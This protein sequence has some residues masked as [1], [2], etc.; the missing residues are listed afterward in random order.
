MDIIINKKPVSVPIL[1][2]AA[3]TSL[4]ILGFSSARVASVGGDEVGVFVNNL[5]GTISVK[6]DA[7]SSIYN[8]IYTDFYTLKK[9]ERTIKMNKSH[10]DEVRIK[11]GDGSDIELDVDIN[12]RLIAD[13]TSIR[14][15]VDE[16]GIAKVIPYKSTSGRRRTADELVDAYHEKWIRDYSRSITRHVFGELSPKEFYD[17]GRRDAQAQKSL[18]ELNMELEPH[19]IHVTQVVP[20]EYAYYEEYKEL[21]DLKKA[22]DQE[23]ENQIE[24]AKTAVKDQ[25]RQVKEAEAKVKALI[26]EREGLLKKELLSAEADSAKARLGIEAEAYNLRTNADAQLTKATNNAQAQ[27]ALASAEAE[28]LNKLANSLAGDGGLNLVKLKYAEVLK[29]ATISGVPYST[30]PRIQKV[31]LDT[32]NTSLGAKR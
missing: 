9:T 17:S 18:D 8:G 16:C 23:V 15:I 12:Y 30:D 1:P 14:S 5:T 28:G 13:L 24:E 29:N 31:E 19:G 27:F 7:G 26:A 22:A 4:V 3:L 11:T 20:G 32:K 2:I 10:N 21:I 6:L 25:E